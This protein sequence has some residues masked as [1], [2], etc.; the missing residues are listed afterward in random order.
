MRRPQKVMP[1]ITRDTIEEAFEDVE[2]GSLELESKRETM[3]TG[4]IRAIPVRTGVLALVG[5][6]KGQVAYDAQVTALPGLTVEVRIKGFSKSMVLNCPDIWT[7]VVPGDYLISAFEEPEQI[8]VLAPA[9]REFQSI[10]V[11]YSLDFIE[12]L[13]DAKLLAAAKELFAN[14]TR[15]QGAA[16]MQVRALAEQIR[17]T[18]PNQDLAL[19][20]AQAACVSLLAET[21]ALNIG[22]DAHSSVF[23]DQVVELAKKFILQETAAHLT[24]GDVAAHCRIS[25]S[26]LKTLFRSVEGV[27]IG[28]FIRKNRMAAA[29]TMLDE[30]VPI[31]RVAKVMQYSAPEALT[32]AYTRHYGYPPS[33]AGRI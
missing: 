28:T 23:D 33:R 18:D 10:S 3:A 2:I 27:P 21:M 4:D 29:K 1:D 26:T 31:T 25:A 32:R 20:K 9:Q 14:G 12:T 22:D 15:F 30:G 5:D 8:Q 19:V 11:C 13:G 16:P 17:V 24:V 7:E 6:F